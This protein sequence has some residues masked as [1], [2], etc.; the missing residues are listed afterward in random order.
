MVTH[1][2][3]LI[4][5]IC[6]IC[7]P[8]FGGQKPQQCLTCHLKHFTELGSCTS[9]H[10][11]NPESAR[12]NIAHYHL[13][14]GQFARYKLVDDAALRDGR[15]LLKQF[16]CRR[17]HVSDGKGNSL[18]ANLD[19]LLNGRSPEEITAAILSPAMGMPDF[20]V[21]K[22]QLVMLVNAI[23]DGAT[24]KRS[25]KDSR[26][27]VHFKDS[28]GIKDDIFNKKCGACH[29]ALTAKFGVLGAGKAGP[30]L[31]AILSPWYLKTFNNSLEWN[32]ER[33]HNWVKNP[34]NVRIN[35][36]MQ[37]IT[38]LEHEFKQLVDI[39]AINQTTQF[40]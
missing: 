3:L 34:R 37:P 18:A 27:I 6:L 23:L 9:C 7:P 5:I 1:I 14:K 2:S 11:G 22:Q 21:S 35:T 13:I 17:C 33:L 25:R 8:V 24:D 26:K 40:R 28:N 29:Q 19:F 39:L 12:K 20:K 32:R 36:G 38:L 4:L 15:F 31:S 16:A 10:A 30:N